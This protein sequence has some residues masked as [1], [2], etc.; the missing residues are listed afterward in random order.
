MA[1]Y[2]DQLYFDAITATIGDIY[3]SVGTSFKSRIASMRQLT[4]MY[5]RRLIQHNPDFDLELGDFRTINALKA[6]GIVE[7][8]FWKAYRTIQHDGNDASH[9]KKYTLP[10]KE[11]FNK[12]ARAVVTIQ[13]YLFFDFFKKHRFGSNP[14]I[15]RCFSLLPPFF[16]LTVLRELLY[17]DPEN[18]ETIHKLGLAA[19]KALGKDGALQFIED[20][21]DQLQKMR[22]P[23]SSDDAKA[24]IGKVGPIIY[25]QILQRMSGSLYDYLKGEIEEHGDTFDQSPIR[26]S[27]FEDA[28]NYFT[29]YGRIKSSSTDAVEFNALMEYIYMGR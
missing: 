22:V 24:L 13:A 3:N 14:E 1:K 17:H 9:T 12:V 18:M 6:A 8:F 19:M 21:E 16:R 10:T 20:E 23:F 2:S 27:S 28:K 26:Y 15:E 7:K 25:A 5:V 29:E 4:E 11:D